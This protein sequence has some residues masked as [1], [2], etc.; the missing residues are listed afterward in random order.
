MS[1]DPLLVSLMRRSPTGAVR[2]IPGGGIGGMGTSTAT[3]LAE[4]DEALAEA[5]RRGF[6]DGYA[7][8]VHDWDNP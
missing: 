2:H 1:A 4:Y 5:Y 8:G 7:V 6:G 3:F